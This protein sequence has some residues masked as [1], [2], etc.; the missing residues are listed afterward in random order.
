MEQTTICHYCKKEI[1]GRPFIPVHSNFTYHWK[2]YIEKIKDER[3]PAENLDEIDEAK[4]DDS[5]S[6]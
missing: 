2:C 4:E 3:T 5:E 1:K 6:L